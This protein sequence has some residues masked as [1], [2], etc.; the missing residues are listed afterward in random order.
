MP[1]AQARLKASQVT[2]ALEE[3]VE[4]RKTMPLTPNVPRTPLR[5][6]RKKQR[7]EVIVEEGEGGS[8]QQSPGMQAS[9]STYQFHNF[10]TQFNR[11]TQR[12][13]LL[14]RLR[15]VDQ[16][17]SRENTIRSLSSTG[18]AHRTAPKSTTAH[19]SFF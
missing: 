18:K 17:T 8:I 4:A 3:A 1:T 11:L 14:R 9:L 19:S 12:Q 6:K 5:V 10:L 7:E 16:N 13:R 2:L 15:L